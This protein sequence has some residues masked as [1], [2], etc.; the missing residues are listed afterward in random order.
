MKPPDAMPSLRRPS[1]TS[2]VL[3]LASR[4]RRGSS[5]LGSA[6]V[7]GVLMPDDMVGYIYIYMYICIHVGVDDG[8]LIKDT[9]DGEWMGGDW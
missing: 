9:K 7:G 4:A 6:D 2:Q 5:R 1:E 3:R 8:L